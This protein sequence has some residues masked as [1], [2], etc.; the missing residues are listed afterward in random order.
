[1]KNLKKITTG[2]LLSTLIAS[3]AIGA[4][5]WINDAKTLF[6]SN[7]AIAYSVNLRTFNAF[8]K[9]KNGIIEE[10]LG[11][12]RGTFLNAI[13]RLDE[14]RKYGVNTIMLMPITPVG[15][16]K[17]LGTAGSL[18]AISE[19]DMLNPQLKD[20]NSKLSL[21]EQAQKFIDECHKRKIRV[22]VDLPCCG[23]YD[24][25][26]KRPNLFKRDNQNHSITPADWTDVRILKTGTNANINQDVFNL[27][28]DFIKM[29]VGLDIDGVRVTVPGLKPANFWKKLIKK[30]AK[31]NPEFVF[32]AETTRER[33]ENSPLNGLELTSYDKL[34][35]AGFD[36]YHGNYSDL[37]D[38]KTAKDL[39]KEVK[40]NL[41]LSEQ[42][43]LKGQNVKTLGTFT[44]HD[45][46]SP[47]L[48]KGPEFSTM[49][50]WLNATLPLNAY[51]IDG[52]QTGDTY[53]YPLANKKAKKSF[54]DDEYY[55]THR[56]KMDIFNFAKRPQGQYNN[57]LKEFVMANRFKIMASKIVTEGNFK[58]LKTSS[59]TAF[60]YSRNLGETTVIVMGNLD[61]KEPQDIKVSV[62][63]LTNELISI[64]IKISTA[65]LI[66]KNKIKT[67]LAPGEVQVLLFE[68][69]QLK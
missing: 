9:N 35:D 6:L 10:E 39:E 24:L 28:D 51:Y 56:G 60:A 13:E 45:E 65:P 64:P 68:G 16:V 63:K 15:K 62:P 53:M 44:T 5:L 31:R 18:Y 21:E 34:L 57:I 2:I 40:F 52:F 69:L 37:K 22:I 14:L 59:K 55:F 30:T 47:I 29:A 49:I 1:M 38:W 26:I 3:K 23:A 11:E 67:T 66:L 12:K 48:Q 17:A 61:F 50:A 58:M 43:A 32:I 7:D 33:Q 20:K 19:F 27:Y 42:R 46:L 54:T 36:V 41:K 8:D 25:Y 4:S